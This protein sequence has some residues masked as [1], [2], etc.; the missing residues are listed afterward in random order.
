MEQQLAVFANEMDIFYRQLKLECPDKIVWLEDRYKH[1]SGIYKTTTKNVLSL[2]GS[3]TAVAGPS[4]A[5]AGP[6]TSD[7]SMFG[8]S[9]SDQSMFGPSTSDHPMA[10]P[11]TQKLRSTLARQTSEEKRKKTEEKQKEIEVK[12]RSSVVPNINKDFDI[13]NLDRSGTREAIKNNIKR[14]ANQIEVDKAKT[15]NN[16]CL[17]GSEFIKLK[18]LANNRPLWWEEAGQDI[19]YGK[20]HIDFL[21]KLSKTTDVY[22]ALAYCSVSIHF[23]KKNFVIIKKIV[24]KDPDFWKNVPTNPPATRSTNPFL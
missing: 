21:I 7:Q 10:G 23:V 2:A 19:H 5:V 11:S 18:T 24:T 3:S 16:Y 9:T 20:S 22:S 14:L 17:L 4:S 8:P 13:K 6:S 12:L 15:V 1:L